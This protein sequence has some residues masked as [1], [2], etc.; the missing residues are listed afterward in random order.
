MPRHPD[1]VVT[2]ALGRLASGETARATAEALGVPIRTVRS[3][4]RRYGEGRGRR[5][6]LHHAAC[7]R[8]HDVPLD[9]GPYAELLG[10]YL[11][12]GHI[13]WS[14]R[15]T[16][17]LAV[18]N[19]ARYVGLTSRLLEV[20]TQVAPG[21]SPSTRTRHGCVVIASSWTHWPCL[22]PQHGP[23]RKHDRRIVL[24]PWQREIVEQHPGQFLRG[25]FHS[26]GCRVQNWATR[27]VDG[28]TTRYDGYPRY[29]FTNRSDDLIALC[30]WALDLLGVRWTLPRAD[31]VSVA[32]R[33]AVAVLDAHVGPKS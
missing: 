20:I 3:W 2:E 33:E 5:G 12:D 6:G 32:R 28:V 14:G 10:W 29:F 9:P 30:T 13:G 4:W 25:L 27:T 24:E 16:P 22:L 17:Q 1:H 31:N 19:D 15:R 11:G 21:T 8:C 7:A 23:G 18:Y 26:D